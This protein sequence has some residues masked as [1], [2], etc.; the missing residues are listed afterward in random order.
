MIVTPQQLQISF[1]IDNSPWWCFLFKNDFIDCCSLLSLSLA[2]QTTRFFLP[3]LNGGFSNVHIDRLVDFIDI[4]QRYQRMTWI[5]FYQIGQALRNL[6]PDAKF[7]LLIKIY[8][9]TRI[10]SA[11]IQTILLFLQ[12][13]I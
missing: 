10:L 12:T 11:G 8:L 3:F 7:K 13:H 6:R 2:R 9:L 1:F 5:F 4:K